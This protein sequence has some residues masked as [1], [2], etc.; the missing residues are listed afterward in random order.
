MLYICCVCLFR[1]FFFLFLSLHIRVCFTRHSFFS[2]PFLCDC[3]THSETKSFV[4]YLILRSLYFFSRLLFLFFFFSLSLS[5]LFFSRYLNLCLV[6]LLMI[7]S[8]NFSVFT[9]RYL[10]DPLNIRFLNTYIYI[11]NEL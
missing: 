1:S 7:V 5:V 6:C 11:H 2:C 3:N 8:S 9:L 4:E 10:S